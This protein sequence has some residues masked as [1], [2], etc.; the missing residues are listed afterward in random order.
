MEM[1]DK[2]KQ[3]GKDLRTLWMACFYAMDELNVPF[4][5]QQ[6]GDRNFFTLR[7]C[8]DCRASWL[9]TIE[10]WFNTPVPTKTT[11]GI[12]VRINGAVEF[13]SPEEYEKY[14]NH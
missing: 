14:R 7:V 2:C 3:V 4:L 11:E 6:V 13:L 1:C 12:P 5:Q 10:I 9:K 8:K